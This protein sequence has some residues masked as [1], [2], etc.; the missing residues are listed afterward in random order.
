MK[1]K[2]TEYLSVKGVRS[3]HLGLPCTWDK[4]NMLRTAN[5]E[6]LATLLIFVPNNL[7]WQQ[8]RFRPVIPSVCFHPLSDGVIIIGDETSLSAAPQQNNRKQHGMAS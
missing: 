7:A 6:T 2:V 1:P 4:K 3:G 8:M 5:V